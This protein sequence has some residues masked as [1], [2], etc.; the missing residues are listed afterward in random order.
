MF[1]TNLELEVLQAER[2]REAQQHRLLRDYRGPSLFERVI[3]RLRTIRL[4]EPAEPMA[5][6]APCRDAV[7]TSR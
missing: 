5:V 4:P 1:P 6:S 3:A 7:A 2:L